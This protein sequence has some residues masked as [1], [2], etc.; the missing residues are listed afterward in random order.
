MAVKLGTI[1]TDSITGF[2]GVAV[3]RTE[4]IHGCARIVIQPKALHEGKIVEAQAFDELQLVGHEPKAVGTEKG[5]PAPIP[6]NRSIP[7]R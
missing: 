7:S 2:S 1:V 6:S 4:Y 3:S 5:G